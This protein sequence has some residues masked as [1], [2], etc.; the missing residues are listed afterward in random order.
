MNDNRDQR[1]LDRMRQVVDDNK[2]LLTKVRKAVHDLN[3]LRAAQ[4]LQEN[5]PADGRQHAA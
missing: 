5:E 1:Q 3:L 4:S 2:E